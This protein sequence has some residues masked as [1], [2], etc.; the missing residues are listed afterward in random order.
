MCFHLVL[1]FTD[2]YPKE[3]PKVCLSTPYPHPNVIRR[4][5]GGHEV[6][7]D[8]LTPMG[9]ALMNDGGRPYERWSSAFSVRS[10]LMQLS[11]FIGVIGRC[12]HC[13]GV[14]PTVLPVPVLSQQRGSPSP[15]IMK[16]T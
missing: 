4:N 13:C 9:S 1:E 16:V 2:A 15:M 3:P 8:M 6:C 11:S 5:A 14:T 12:E 10:V 7:M